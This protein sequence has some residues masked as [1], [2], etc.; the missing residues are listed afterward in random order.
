MKIALAQINPTVGDFEGNS[1]RIV[2][3][4]K[5]ATE[6]GAELTLF[7]ELSLMGY[8]ARDLLDR[9]AFLAAQDRALDWLRE[10]LKGMPAIVGFVRRRQGAGEG[11]GLYNSCAMIVNGEIAAVGDKCLLPT[12]DV[13]DEDRY[14]ES[15]AQPSAVSFK[16]S[17]WGLTICEDCWNDKDFWSQRKYAVDPIERL[18]ADDVAVLVNISASPFSIGKQ[19]VKERMLSSLARKHHRALLYVNQVGGNDD[20]VF[21]GRSL[22]FDKHG[23][24]LARGPAFEEAVVVVDMA[25]S[26]PPFPPREFNASASGCYPSGFMLIEEEEVRRALVLGTKDY[27]RKCGFKTAVLG[28]SGGI[29]SAVVAA[30]AVE[31]FGAENVTGVAMPSK[32][33]SPESLAD[34]KDLAA[35]LKIKFEVVP[36]EGLAASFESALKIPFAGKKEDV[37]EENLQARI[38][39]TLLMAYSNKF[40]HLLLTTGNKSELATGYCTMYGDMCGGL[41]VISDLYKTMVYRLAKH[42]NS[43]RSGEPPIPHSSITKAPTAELRLNQTDQDTLPPY[44]MLDA[45]LRLSI[46]EQKSAEEIVGLGFGRDVVKKVV[47]MIDL[48]EYKRRQAAPGLKITSKAFGTGRRM[49]IAQRF[50][51]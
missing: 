16:G 26:P 33:N 50:R 20:L 7:P 49:P 13:F 28:L 6:Q 23:K 45:I 31:A 29:D 24:L 15:A 36:I 34:A 11:K 40:G 1:Q 21:D 35:R 32:F 25:V 27:A 30:I 51:E 42:L 44:E 37:T 4:A 18:I 14:F 17:R 48:N 5:E 39:G 46:E 8:P 10:A 47:R 19:A 43:L 9:P 38:R 22:A 3:S 41:A 2:D 12:Y